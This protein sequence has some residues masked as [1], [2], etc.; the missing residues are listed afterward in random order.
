MTIICK[1][2]ETC[3]KGKLQEVGTWERYKTPFNYRLSSEVPIYG[4][5][6]VCDNEECRGRFCNDEEDE[7]LKTY[8]L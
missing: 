7:T 2:C 4:T 5:V 1:T 3:E 8:H 6:Y